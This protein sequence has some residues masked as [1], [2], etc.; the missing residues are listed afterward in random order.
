MSGH[1]YFRVHIY[2]CPEAQVQAVQQVLAHHLGVLFDDGEPLDLSDSYS[3]EEAR[4]EHIS[5]FMAD[6]RKAGPGASWIMWTDPA[7]NELGQLHAYT[8]RFGLYGPVSCDAGGDVVFTL[9]EMLNA[10]GRVPPPS[11]QAIIG[12]LAGAM[13]RPWLED[14]EAHQ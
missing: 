4:T 7:G 5:Q 8:P 9:A 2:A 13:G 6:L 3:V 12:A 10:L 14:W 1:A 11:S